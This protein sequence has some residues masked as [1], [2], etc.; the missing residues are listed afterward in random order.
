MASL[1]LS[2][3]YHVHEFDAA[4]DDAGAAKVLETQHWPYHAFDR[5]VVLVG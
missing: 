4:Q 1:H 3:R 5:P 2:F